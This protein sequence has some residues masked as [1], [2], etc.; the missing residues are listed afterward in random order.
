M[1]GAERRTHKRYFLSNK[2]NVPLQLK[3]SDQLL[4][5]RLLN[6]SVGGIGLAVSK[7][8]RNILLKADEES[9]FLITSIMDEDFCFLK[10]K[11]IKIK[12]I[13]SS[14]TLN[15]IGAGCEF[16]NMDMGLTDQLKTVFGENEITVN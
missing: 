3:L 5:A 1:M 14:D 4:E 2:Q 6:I 9:N 12:W 15:S 10:D 13:L 11:K 7:Q 8:H 16:V